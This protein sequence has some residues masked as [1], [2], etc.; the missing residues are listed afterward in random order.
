[1]QQEEFMAAD[2]FCEVYKVEASFINSLQEFGLIEVSVLEEKRFI[3]VSRIRELEKL[4]R[5]HY[6]LDINIPGIE[7]ILHLLQRVN[8]LQGEISVLKNR[9]RRYE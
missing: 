8:D 9:L 3:D 7:A 2:Q 4:I 1:M 5:L 6:D